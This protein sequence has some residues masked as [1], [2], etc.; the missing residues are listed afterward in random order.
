MIFA[1]SMLAAAILAFVPA[2]AHAEE[3]PA[4]N[5]LEANRLDPAQVSIAFQYTGGV[6][7]EVGTAELGETVDGTLA[8]RFPTIS[9]SE[10]CTLQAVEIDVEQTIEADE[11]V[12]EVEVTLLAPDG[13]AIA[14]GIHSLDQD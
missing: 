8:V 11:S 4:F 9:T 7:E 10:M 1:R 14:T 12:T 13:R 5:T 2:L 3:P 6:C